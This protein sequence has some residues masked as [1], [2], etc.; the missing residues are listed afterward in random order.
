MKSKKNWKLH[1]YKI[2]KILYSFNNTVVTTDIKG[3]IKIHE[4]NPED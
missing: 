4:Y 1:D 2:N 3:I